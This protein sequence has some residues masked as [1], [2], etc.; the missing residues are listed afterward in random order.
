MG[1]GESS[2][3][4]KP[5]VVGAGVGIV[6]GIGV[7]LRSRSDDMAL[8]L[9]LALGCGATAGALGGLAISIKEMLG[10]GFLGTLAMIFIMLILLIVGGFAAA[11]ML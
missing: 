3:R 7:Y 9:P 11:I 5:I 1:Y 2:S 4:L 10:G 8:S 6:L